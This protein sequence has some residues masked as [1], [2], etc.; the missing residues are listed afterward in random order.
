MPKP[1][2]VEAFEFISEGT[3]NEI[4][5]YIAFGLFM[6]S[7]DEWVSGLTQLP[8]NAEYK[9]YHEGLLT[10]YERE[11]F[12]TGAATVL[13]DFAAKAIQAERT[14]LLKHHWKFR[15]FGVLEAVLG[16]FLWTVLLVVITILVAWGGIDIFEYY[17][18]ANGFH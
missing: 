5:D 2:H 13:E 3:K 6:R 15:C 9:K 17:K 12:R 8:T 7:E 4:R 11:R 18:R 14:D 1:A 16:A 10:P